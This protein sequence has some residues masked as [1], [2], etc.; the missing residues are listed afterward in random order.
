MIKKTLNK[1]HRGN[2]FQRNKDKLTANIIL[3]LKKLKAFSLIQEQDKDIQSHHFYSTQYCK[4]QP[5]QLGN[6]KKQ[7]ST[8]ER[9]KVNLTLFADDVILYINK[10]IYKK[11]FH[12]PKNPVRIHEFSKVEEY[13][14]KIQEP[15]AF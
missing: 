8:L 4:S 12:P 13:N 14:S 7:T 11:R 9:K 3:N 1:L 5:E 10:D 6:K 2:I 15:G